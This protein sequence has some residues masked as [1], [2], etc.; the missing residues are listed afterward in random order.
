MLNICK[1]LYNKLEA[2]SNKFPLYSL[3]TLKAAEQLPSEYHSDLAKVNLLKDVDVSTLKEA[4]NKAAGKE[5]N[6][7]ARAVNAMAGKNTCET[8]DA[9]TWIEERESKD[10]RKKDKKY[11]IIGGYD[12]GNFI[13]KI[14]NFLDKAL[15][16]YLESGEAFGVHVA[17]IESTKAKDFMYI[18]PAHRESKENGSR[19]VNLNALAK[20]AADVISEKFDLSL[21]E[22]LEIMD[23]TNGYFIKKLENAAISRGL[24]K[25]DYIPTDTR[26]FIEDGGRQVFNLYTPAEFLTK[27]ELKD[28]LTP[29]SAVAE[30]KQKAPATYTLMKN[31]FGSDNYVA[32]MLNRVAFIA[33]LRKKTQIG[34]IVYGKQGAGKNLY[35]KHVAGRLVGENNWTIVGNN[36][37]DTRF[38]APVQGKLYIVGNEV[39][40]NAYEDKRHSG[41]AEQ[42]KTLIT[43]DRA[44]L[45]YKNFDAVEVKNY[46]NI[47]IFSNKP[48]PITIDPDD[49]RYVIFNAE[50]T[51]KEAVGDTHDFVAKL[52]SEYDAV[53]EIMAR[54]AIDE[55]LAMTAVD[56]PK[57]LK[58]IL[59]TNTVGDIIKKRLFDEI[60][61]GNE[62]AR[63]TFAELIGETSESSF[64]KRLID[65]AE[66]GVMTTADAIFIHKKS[67]GMKEDETIGAA[68]IMRIVH[69]YV[70]ESLQII[71]VYGIDS[72][73][74][75]FDK[76]VYVKDE[77]EAESGFWLDFTNNVFVMKLYGKW[78]AVH[79]G[80][81]IETKYEIIQKFVQQLK[82]MRVENDGTAKAARVISEI[83]NAYYDEIGEL[84][85]K[86]VAVVKEIK[87]EAKNVK[88]DYKLNAEDLM[89]ME[90]HEGKS[91]K[92][93]KAGPQND[94][95]T[96]TQEK[97][98][99]QNDKQRTS[100]EQTATIDDDALDDAIPF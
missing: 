89:N 32:Y 9:A 65:N 82:A 77:K 85:E 2:K 87:D 98:V 83:Q 56:T 67:V 63:Q 45:E 30:L 69:K 96:I 5:P 41:V 81:A 70:P 1:K 58:M 93:E 34:V 43:E 31:L 100:D 51:L 59:E 50:T 10:G 92:C 37:L 15:Y 54:F 66:R 74:R 6:E 68:Q 28:E 75:K 13:N 97:A 12:A 16:E 26:R 78:I 88:R 33:K 19:A 94:K 80:E 42:L 90:E 53:D 84:G 18:T 49:R 4:L 60:G 39:I 8:I 47:D 7:V 64:Y 99:A 29:T 95:E 57:K 27:Y 25:L 35:A 72:S 71:R 76:R 61:E 14:K 44:F 40:L 46:A 21:A 91:E 17:A 23:L 11:A 55:K 48:A 22:R 20:R 36:Q 86:A 73:G 24:Y 3:H 79:S 52:E 38:N 62:S